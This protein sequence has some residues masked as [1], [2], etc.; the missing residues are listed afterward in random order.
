MLLVLLF[1]PTRTNV[2]PLKHEMRIFAI[3]NAKN[4]FFQSF[5]FKFAICGQL[6][7]QQCCTR[8]T[9]AQQQTQ[10]KTLG[11]IRSSPNFEGLRFFQMFAV[12]SER[13]ESLTD[14]NIE[15]SNIFHKHAF[16]N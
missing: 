8:S 14:L 16:L 15:N 9:N 1:K 5:F 3:K 13:F 11:R 12:E 2:D 4:G 7:A 6:L 10:Y